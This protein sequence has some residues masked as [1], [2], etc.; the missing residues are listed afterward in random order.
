MAQPSGVRNLRLV[1]AGK[2]SRRSRSPVR[3]APS[4]PQ[5][6]C[7]KLCR[8]GIWQRRSPHLPVGRMATRLMLRLSRRRS[9]LRLGSGSRTAVVRLACHARCDIV[10]LANR[11]MEEQCVS[12]PSRSSLSANHPANQNPTLQNRRSGEGWMLI[13]HNVFKTSATWMTRPLP[14]VPTA[15]ERQAAAFKSASGCRECRKLTAR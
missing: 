14:V 12:R 5:M 2:R 15:P 10:A 9:L 11:S 6:G 7:R 13:L 3:H 4:S 1:V 8:E